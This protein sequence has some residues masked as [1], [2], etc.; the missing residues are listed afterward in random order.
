[1]KLGRIVLAVVAL[2][3]VVGL[4][5][6]AQNGASAGGRMV[7]AASALLAFIQDARAASRHVTPTHLVG[8]ALARALGAVPDLNVRLLGDRAVPREAV[9]IFFIAAIGGPG[10][11]DL[12]GVKVRR[13]D[14][15]D[16]YGVAG[17]LDLRAA[18][19]DQ[20]GAAVVDLT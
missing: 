17:E 9:D 19:T 10:A 16:V 18:S 15:R 5:R 6:V 1:M 20:Y 3:T 14:E 12:S 4:A 2:A 13:V 11:Q 7:S 8:R